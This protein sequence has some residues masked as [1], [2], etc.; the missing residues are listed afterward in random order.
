MTVPFN[1]HK[2]YMK[3][4]RPRTS[5]KY[6]RLVNV[7][8]QACGSGYVLPGSDLREKKLGSGSELRKKTG[9]RILLDF[10][11]I[12]V[13]S[14]F[15]VRQIFFY[16]IYILILYYHCLKVCTSLNLITSVKSNQGYQLR[17]CYLMYI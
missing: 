13:Y 4:H 2:I 10:Y 17:L 16:K 5:R 15:S 1:E 3:R 7:P 11:P 14:N 12:N 8:L 6:M 9:I